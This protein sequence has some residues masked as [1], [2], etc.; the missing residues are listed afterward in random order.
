MT[1]RPCGGVF[2]TKKHEV[3]RSHAAEFFITKKHEVTRIL[4]FIIFPLRAAKG[5]EGHADDFTFEA[6]FL[7]T[8]IEV[9]LRASSCAF[10]VKPLI[11][12]ASCLFVPLRGESHL[13]A[14]LRVPSWPNGPFAV[15]LIRMVFAAL[16]GPSQIKFYGIA[17]PVVLQAC[18]AARL[19][20]SS[21]AFVVKPLIRRAS[22]LFV[23]LRGEAQNRR[24]LT[25]SW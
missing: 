7:Q 13:S 19:R 8:C 10:V 24:A 17:E 1:R 4:G 23:A 18:F 2:A 20:A 12:K 9:G 15:R 16:S 14:R 5:R 3:T 22:C 6:T 25:P 21:C 11:R